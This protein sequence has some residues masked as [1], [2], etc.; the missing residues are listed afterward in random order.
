[1]GRMPSS[2]RVLV[3]LLYATAAATVAVEVLNWAYAPEREFGLAVRTGWAMLR[4]LG[5]LLLVWHVH[6]GRA[7]A[8]PFG[9]ILAVTTVF[10]VGRLVVPREG[11]PPLPGVI[12]FAVLTALCVAVVWLLYR[13]PSLQEHLVNHPGRLVID[14]EGVSW[15]RNA[16]RRAPVAAWLITSRIAAFT[17]APLMLVPTLVSVGVV[18]DGRPG[19]APLVVL[20]FVFGVV[21][22]NLLLPVTIFLLRGKR[23]ARTALVVL[24]GAVLAVDLPLC[25]ALLGLDGLVRDGA[26]LAV[27]AA[28]ALVGLWRAGRPVASPADRTAE[29]AVA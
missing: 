9:L 21:V 27:A 2:V 20:W 8:K 17:F 12:G 24:T 7:G 25:W 26:P 1:M 11:V 29:P 28:I 16:P 19:A 22:A 23:W 10:A 6:R 14:R 15:Q 13:A 3:A 4:S 5:F 18:F